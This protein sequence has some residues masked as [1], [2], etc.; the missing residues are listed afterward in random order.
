MGALDLEPRNAGL[1]AETKVEFPTSTDD[2][3]DQ[4]RCGELL[5]LCVA[6][7][8]AECGPAL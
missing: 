1:P 5:T 3:H 7:H 6:G 2:P 8:T 4:N